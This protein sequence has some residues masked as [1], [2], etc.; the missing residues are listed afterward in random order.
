M[1]FIRCCRW[2]N[3]GRPSQFLLE[4]SYS[5]SPGSPSMS[6]FSKASACVRVSIIRRDNTDSRVLRIDMDL[7]QGRQARYPQ[8]IRQ[9]ARLRI[10]G[11]FHGATAFVSTCEKFCNN[12]SE[13]KRRRFAVACS[14]TERSLMKT[15]VRRNGYIKVVVFLQSSEIM[16]LALDRESGRDVF[17][18]PNLETA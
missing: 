11:Y 7:R 3:Q 16:Y 12:A 6:S 2:Q 1:T 4:E 8:L 5:L 18:D 15:Q 14:G 10:V 9:R 17:D 13:N